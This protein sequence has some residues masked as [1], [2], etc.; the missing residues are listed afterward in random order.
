MPIE[1]IE[2]GKVRQLKT[3]AVKFISIVD[4]GANKKK[5]ILKSKD[6]GNS[7]WEKV[8]DVLKFYDE[9]HII[10][11]IVYAPGEVDAHGDFDTADVILKSSQ[12]FMKFGKTVNVDKQHDFEPDEGFVCE[13]WIVKEKDFLFPDDVGAWAVGIKIENL[14]TWLQLKKGELTGIS[15]AGLIEG[16][17]VDESQ[18]TKS[19]DK[20]EKAVVPYK[21]GKLADVDMG[22]EWST[23]VMN[24]CLGDD[25]DDWNMFKSVHAIFD[26]DNKE[27]K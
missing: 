25:G 16:V 14:E 2:K 8:V 15:L 24:K 19:V 27:S 17:L 3:I 7:N 10:Y 20:I 26:P 1:T 23:K 5:V 6:G 11:G 22:W 9:K 4:V 21:K 12:D 18:V 13:C